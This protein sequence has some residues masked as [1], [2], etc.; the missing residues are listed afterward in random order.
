MTAPKLLSSS[1]A[2]F[3]MSETDWTDDLILQGTFQSTP[4]LEIRWK[5]APPPAEADSST[6]G[7]T[8]LALL[9]NLAQ[10]VEWSIKVPTINDV[11]APVTVDLKASFEGDLHYVG[12]ESIA[13]L[14]VAF[15]SPTTQKIS[16]FSPPSFG[17]GRGLA[18]FQPCLDSSLLSDTPPDDLSFDTTISTIQSPSPSHARTKTISQTS[19]SSFSSFSRTASGGSSSGGQSSSLPSLL[20]QQMPLR[21]TDSAGTDISFTAFDATQ[22][23]SPGPS[24]VPKHRSPLSQSDVD[25]RRAPRNDHRMAKC[26]RVAVEVSKVHEVEG[27]WRLDLTGSLELSLGE[28]GTLSLPLLTLR[29]LDDTATSS[30]VSIRGAEGWEIGPPPGSIKSSVFS[31]TTA[32]WDVSLD[33]NLQASADFFTLSRPTPAPAVSSRDPTSATRRHRRG[34]SL[35]SAQA[36][37]RSVGASASLPVDLAS[38]FWVADQ[39]VSSAECIPSVNVEVLLLPSSDGSNV[40]QLTSVTVILPLLA[41]PTDFAGENDTFEFGI[42]ASPST[43]PGSSSANCS[44]SILSAAVNSVP[45]AYDVQLSDEAS[46]EGEGGVMPGALGYVQL[47]AEGLRTITGEIK[48]KYL[49]QHSVEKKRGRAEKAGVDVVLGL[50]SFEEGVSWQETLVQAAD[51]HSL[52]CDSPA[53]T[54]WF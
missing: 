32:S 27:A 24:P 48:V 13:H 18:G 30:R 9:Q 8:H 14:E 53:C 52:S 26:F 31:R 19:T 6:A 36:F 28:D 29:S 11:S 46:L 15:Q 35:A 37:N 42:I 38:P 33:T 54:V 39:S 21:A 50:P 4:Q 16:W 51:G 3:T 40:Q 7:V 23:P 17:A 2:P 49:V 5:P 43:G 20:R 25:P 47:R 41:L 1:S 12:V 34:S 45:V 22:S 44:L 10:S